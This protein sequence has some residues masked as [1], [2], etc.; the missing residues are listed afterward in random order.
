ML[1]WLTA[2]V[3]VVGLVA[4]ALALDDRGVDRARPSDGRRWERVFAPGRVEGVTREIAL[5][6]QIDGPIVRVAVA[7][8]QFVR[9][10]DVLLELDDAPQRH[11]VLLAEA[12][13]AHARAELDRLIAGAREE[14]RQEAIATHEA[15]LAA[16]HGAQQRL[17]R[18]QTLSDQ[19]TVSQ[20]ET[21]DQAALVKSLAGEAAAAEARMRLL[22][23]PA[24]EDEVRISQAEV[25]A[26]EARLRQAQHE[27]QQTRLSAPCQGQVLDVRAELGELAG[28]DSVEPTVVLADT[29]RLFV[30]AF[31]EEYD[32]PRIAVG[33]Q[34][35]AAADGLPDRRLTGKVVRLSPRMT[36]KLARSDLPGERLD[37]EVREVWI[38]LAEAPSMVVGLRVDVTIHTEEPRP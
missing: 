36:R 19:R 28:P 23:A 25:A 26:A 14:E 6:P 21:D 38:E 20:Q 16:L 37:T 7:Q 27:R 12:E 22:Q 8:G 30:R 17:R 10:G 29:A 31:V 9:K 2:A 11:A 4:L 13:L 32:A 35:E 24:R 5:R 34:A 18:L 33:M 3:A 1:K 15:K